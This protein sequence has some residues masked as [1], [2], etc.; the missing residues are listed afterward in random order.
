MGKKFPSTSVMG[1]R[2]HLVRVT[3]SFEKRMSITPELEVV[4]SCVYSLL[5]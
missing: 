5:V 3:V 2:V 1:I 4:G